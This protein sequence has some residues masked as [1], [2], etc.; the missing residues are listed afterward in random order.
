MRYGYWL[1]VFGGW[2]RNVENEGM[3]ATWP[4]VSRLA[5]R[6]EEIGYDLTLIAELNL[7]DI[8]GVEA[9]SLDA[10]ST[11]AALAAVTHRLELMVAVR[12]T[13]HNPALLAK[14]AANIDHISN[15]R[16]SLNVVSSWWAEEAKKYGVQFDQH[17]DRYARTSEWLD[18]VDQAWKQDHVSY[19]GK[20]YRVD[21]LVL[22]PKP[23]SFPRP[24]IYAGGESEAAKNL[25]SQK[26]DA[27]VMHGGPPKRLREKIQDLSARREKWGLP[28]MQFGVAAYAIVRDSEEEAQRELRR[29]TDVRQ[30][31]AGYGN[32]QQWLANTQLEQRLSLEDYSVS[33]RGLRSGLVGTPE[34]VAERVAE[35]EEAGVDLLLLQFSPQLEEME[36]FAAQVIQPAARF[37]PKL[38]DEFASRE[39][40]R[41]ANC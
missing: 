24:V 34:Q 8:K 3:H 5:R 19:H 7:N 14:Q 36:R 21:D 32:Y 1:P 12:P 35:F 31:A 9:P 13:F 10:W 22:Q 28:P 37:G 41:A 15:G 6:S 11:A 25:I 30:N 39:V 27:Y 4:Y 16:V 38:V 40:R 17:D 26:C 23:I 33:N 20:Y 29:I 2:L 18:V